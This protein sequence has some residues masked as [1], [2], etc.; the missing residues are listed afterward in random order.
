MDI[1]RNAHFLLTLLRVRAV[2]L[3]RFSYQKVYFYHLQQHLTT[4]HDET[5]IIYPIPKKQWA[6]LIMAVSS[7]SSLIIINYSLE[8]ATISC[9]IYLHKYS[10]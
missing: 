3:G 7:H 1:W 6:F 5:R 10:E 9:S 8:R 2:V 4:A